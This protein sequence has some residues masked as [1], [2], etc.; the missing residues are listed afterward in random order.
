MNTITLAQEVGFT[1][2]DAKRIA[3]AGYDL[4]NAG[5]LEAA[6]DVFKGLLALN[7][8]DALVHTAYGMVLQEQGDESSAVREFDSALDEDPKMAVALLNRGIL[9]LKRGNVAGLE[10]LEAVTPLKTSVGERAREIVK[11]FAQR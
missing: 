5:Q 2:Q 11:A 4:L 6:A 10:D 9:K 8:H 3:E 1:E 7:P